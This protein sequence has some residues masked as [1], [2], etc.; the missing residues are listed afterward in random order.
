MSIKTINE[1]IK[2]K[3]PITASHLDG[4]FQENFIYAL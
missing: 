2:R 4:L 1:I 3:A